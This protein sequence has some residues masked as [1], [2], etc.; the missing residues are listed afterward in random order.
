METSNKILK[1]KGHPSSPKISNSKFLNY[2]PFCITTFPSEGRVPYSNLLRRTMFNINPERQIGSV[3]DLV[4]TSQSNRLRRKIRT[5]VNRKTTAGF[6]SS[7]K[8]IREKTRG[9]WENSTKGIKTSSG[10]IIES[11]KGYRLLIQNSDDIFSIIGAGGKQKCISLSIQRITGY[12]PEEQ[13]GKNVIEIVHQDDMKNILELFSKYSKSLRISLPLGF[14]H[15]CK[16]GSYKYLESIGQ[17]LLD[18]S[19]L[20]EIITSTRYISK[21]KKAEKE[22]LQTTSD[23]ERFEKIVVITN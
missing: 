8:D 21:K 12:K 13:I 1:T 5:V 18:D 6:E 9:S 7:F 19:L 23:L 22:L 2:F 11:G 14:R 3:F 10:Q 4:N 16:D 15:K 17:N 20:N